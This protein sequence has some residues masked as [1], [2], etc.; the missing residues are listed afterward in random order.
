[1][2]K[3]E[4]Y[5]AVMSKVKGYISKYWT[6]SQGFVFIFLLFNA[7]TFSFHCADCIRKLST[8]ELNGYMSKCNLLRG[9]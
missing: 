5:T 4:G 8:G 9:K 1:M 6:P 7:C 3:F 2:T